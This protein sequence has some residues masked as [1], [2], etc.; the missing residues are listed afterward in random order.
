MSEVSDSVGVK[1]RCPEGGVARIMPAG[2]DI[3]SGEL[4]VEHNDEP[5]GIGSAAPVVQG[6]PDQVCGRS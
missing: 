1:R 5:A 2:G 3:G 6:R 4:I